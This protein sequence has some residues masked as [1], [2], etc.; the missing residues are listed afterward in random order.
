MHSKHQSSLVKWVL[1]LSA[2]ALFAFGLLVEPAGAQQPPGQEREIFFSVEEE[3]VGFQLDVANPIVSDGDLLAAGF[4]ALGGCRIVARNAQLL[5]ALNGGEFDLGLDAA[6][7][8]DPTEDALLVAFSTSLD[9]FQGLFTAGDLLVTNNAIITNAVLLAN[10]P[11][12]PPELDVGLDALHCRGDPEACRIFFEAFEGQ[13]IDIEDA[14]QFFGLLEESGIDILFSTEGSAPFPDLGFKDGDL[15]SV[16]GGI[17]IPNSALFAVQSGHNPDPDAVDYG[18]DAFTLGRV[19]IGHISPFAARLTAAAAGPVDI[20]VPLYSSEIVSIDEFTDGDMLRAAASVAA[21]NN[22]LI[23]CFGPRARDMGLDALHFGQSV[24]QDC[25]ITKVCNRF[26]FEIDPVTGL[27]SNV[28]CDAAPAR[29]CDRPFG[30]QVYIYGRIQN[31]NPLTHQYRVTFQPAG[32][33]A[34]TGI[35]PDCLGAAP[36]AVITGP[37]CGLPAEPFV[38]DAQGW[39]DLDLFERASFCDSLVPLTI[40][41]SR[42]VADGLYELVLHVREKGADPENIVWES[43]P[44]RVTIDNTPPRCFLRSPSI[45]DPGGVAVIEGW[46]FDEHFQS[47]S[48][49]AGSFSCGGGA[50]NQPQAVTFPLF[51]T[52][53]P[54]CFDSPGPVDCMGTTPSTTPI[55]V[56]N[57][58]PVVVAPNVDVCCVAIN[59]HLSDRAC[60]GRCTPRPFPLPSLLFPALGTGNQRNC[61][62]CFGVSPPLAIVAEFETF[63]RSDANADG[64]VNIG[65]GISI[66][67]FLFAD[68]RRPT[69]MKSADVNDSGAVNLADASFLFESLFGRGPMPPAPFRACGVDPTADE[70]SCKSYEP[71][72]Q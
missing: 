11:N 5:Q 15:L 2:G 58:G 61:L 71:C 47:F 70:L 27:A 54:V 17:V 69:C 60:R 62:D 25:E 45:V 72:V 40:W 55:N 38:S 6:V 57:V 52:A 35:V 24:F 59:M 48:V 3:F 10:F 18:L 68:G 32:G 44:V 16:L 7:V 39:I 9:D 8:L 13:R 65:D 42:T 29:A 37:P 21:L 33:G 56:F 28:P 34:V 19:T 20:P 43:D 53:P 26:V 31:L 14:A 67:S 22:Q 30:F 12:V 4:P 51:P 63:Q 49:Q 41:D 36:P 1:G 46:V 66:L 23:F 50:G 64:D